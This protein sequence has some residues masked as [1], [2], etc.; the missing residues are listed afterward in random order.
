MTVYVVT[1][2]EYSDYCICRVFTDENAAKVYCAV[3]NDK[4]NYDEYVIEEYETD[5]LDVDETL[6][7]TYKYE[8]YANKKGHIGAYGE[9]GL[10]SLKR[11][12]EV[13]PPRKYIPDYH[14]IVYLDEPDAKDRAL[15]IAQ[16]MWAEYKANVVGGLL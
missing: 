1:T 6:E 15:K 8:F 7:V 4:E 9:S 13:I 12:N 5:D 2:G 3:N 10:Y 14:I 11:K 16:D